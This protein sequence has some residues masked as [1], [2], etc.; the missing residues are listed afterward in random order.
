MRALP[1]FVT[2]ERP[3]RGEHFSS[4]RSIIQL[5]ALDNKSLSLQ[6]T[7]NNSTPH[8]KQNQK[9]KLI[10]THPHCQ[11][12]R[13]TGTTALVQAD[14]HTTNLNK[15]GQDISPHALSETPNLCIFF[16][17]KVFLFGNIMMQTSRNVVLCT[18]L[19]FKGLI[20][21]INA[22]SHYK[23]EKNFIFKDV[24]ASALYFFV[25]FRFVQK[26]RKPV[27]QWPSV[28]KY[29][30]SF[31]FFPKTASNVPCMKH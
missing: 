12:W 3:W 19:S 24:G 31:T 28:H 27:Q 13:D 2:L 11:V 20:P 25:Q 23:Q 8:W 5:W 15:T 1:T 18:F 4:Q 16:L 30:K 7:S 14:G 29:K 9:S 17:R 6:N 26:L 22:T 10:Q 21:W